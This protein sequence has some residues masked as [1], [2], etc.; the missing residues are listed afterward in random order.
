MKS[1]ICG[2][3][4]GLLTHAA[5]ADDWTRFRGPNGSGIAPASPAPLTTWSES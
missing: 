3:M 4:L 2:L 5:V 1:L